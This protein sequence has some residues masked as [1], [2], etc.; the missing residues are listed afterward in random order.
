MKKILII[1]AILTY[2]LQVEAQDD[3]I[4]K[5]F[6]KYSNSS[7][8]TSVFIS[9]KMFS[10]IAKI[11]VDEKEKDIRNLIGK[12]EKVQ[13]LTSDKVDG[14]KLYNEAFGMLPKKIYEELMTVKEGE[15]EFKFFIKESEGKIGELLMLKGGKND[16]LI[17]NI[18]GDI[19]LEDISK[20]SKTMDVDGF[21]HLEKVKDKNE[22]KKKL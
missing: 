1:L 4:S 16:F 8:F 14:N 6:G 5:F 7:D 13:I 21:K 9:S 15:E 20:L 10:L 18:I 11:P 2:S 3:A 19:N 12:L 17:L 22:N